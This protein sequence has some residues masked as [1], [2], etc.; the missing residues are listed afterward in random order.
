MCD[1]EAIGAPSIFN[2][3]RSAAALA[4]MFPTVDRSCE[5]NAA[6]RLAELALLV[7]KQTPEAAKR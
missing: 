3:I 6:R 1:L 4:R 2:V 5:E 7:A